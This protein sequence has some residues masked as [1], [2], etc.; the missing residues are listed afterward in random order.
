MDITKISEIELK[1]NEII[2]FE[3]LKMQM[4]STK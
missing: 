3:D 2:N 1:V 4:E